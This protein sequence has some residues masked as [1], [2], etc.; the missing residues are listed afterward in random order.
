LR[1]E[2]R[3]PMRMMLEVTIR[4]K[5]K[6]NSANPCWVNNAESTRPNSKMEITEMSAMR[7]S[8]IRSAACLVGLR[9]WAKSDAD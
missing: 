6:Q 2:R 1:I 3:N 7:A 5:V 8:I 9:K 4:K